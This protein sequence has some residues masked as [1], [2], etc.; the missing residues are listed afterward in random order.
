MNRL[1]GIKV[2]KLRKE[3]NYSQEEVADMLNVS[4]ATY[5]RIENGS[6]SAWV[7]YINILSDLYKITIDDFLKL[8]EIIPQNQSEEDR[9]INN[10]IEQ[11]ETRLKEKDRLI[12]DLHL[13]I[14]KLINKIN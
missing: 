5:S 9:L 10:L 14:D 12:R 4:Q 3:R 2:K 7:N 6:T 13:K 1:I 11:Y 8:E